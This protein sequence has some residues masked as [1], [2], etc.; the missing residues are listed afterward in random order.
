MR[1]F[2]SSDIEGTT[3]ITAWDETEWS[4][5]RSVYFREQMT[6]EVSAACEGAIDAGFDDIWVKDAHD[7]ARNILPD[8][9]PEPVKLLRGWI[10]DT[11]SMMGGINRNS[12]DAVIFTGYHSWA[13][14]N[15]NPLAHTM[16]TENEYVK[17]NGEFVSEFVI[18]A[19][20][21]GYYGVPVCFVSGDKALCEQAR[22][23]VPNIT[24]FAVNEGIGGAVLSINPNL[25]VRLMREK[26]K[27]SLSGDLSL[28]KVRMPESF[29]IEIRF[30]KHQSALHMSNYPNASLEDNKTVRFVTSEWLQAMKFIDFAI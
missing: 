13:A 6:R 8:K 7:S 17:I 28:C 5:P 30:R 22:Q 16:N 10:G 1:L 21:A 20:I 24:S 19:Y 2:V 11:H 27:E 3:G 9:L 14:G 26:V 15:G 23:Y 18:N 25:A 12:F 4:T 29:D